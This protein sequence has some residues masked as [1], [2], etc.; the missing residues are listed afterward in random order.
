M[1]RIPVFA[2]LLVLVAGPAAAEPLEQEALAPLD[3]S[4]FGEGANLDALN[5]DVSRIAPARG[6]VGSSSPAS[7]RADWSRKEN[8]DG[9]SAVTVKRALPTEWDS[10]VGLD[11]SLARP[12][13]AAPPLDT[14][15]GGQTESTGAAWATITAPSL[16]LPAGWDKATLDAR[17]D[18]SADQRRLGTTLSKSVPLNDRLSVTLQNGAA[19]THQGTHPGWLDSATQGS[20]N[21]ASDVYSAESSARLKMLPTQTTIGVGAARSSTD[22]RWLRTFSTEQKLFG[23]ISVTGAISET[24]E[25]PANRSLTAGF[26]RNW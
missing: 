4:V 24:P 3:P 5:W 2:V 14:L 15:Q 12:Q 21:A 7:P 23:D 9:S 1:I 22:D 6:H 20:A 25:G 19:V 17:V 8:K 16:N 11:L 18:P 10:K 26:K 13:G